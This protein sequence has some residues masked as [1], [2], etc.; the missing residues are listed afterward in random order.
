MTET[1]FPIISPVCLCVCVSIP[2]HHLSLPLTGDHVQEGLPKVVSDAAV[3]YHLVSE[4]DQAQVV[5]VL[6]IVLLYVNPVLK[7]QA[8]SQQSHVSATN[9]LYNITIFI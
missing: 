9:Q 1:V 6:H 4:D 8:Q 3:A 2:V 5:H 7:E